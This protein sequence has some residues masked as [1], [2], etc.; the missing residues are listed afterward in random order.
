MCNKVTKR[1]LLV[2]SIWSEEE[3]DFLRDSASRMSSS[4]IAHALGRTVAAVRCKAKKLGVRFMI[5]HMKDGTIRRGWTSDEVMTLYSLSE[6]TTLDHAAERLKRSPHAVKKKASKLGISFRQGRMTLEDVSRILGISKNT[7]RRKRDRL[8]LSFRK[9]SKVS[10]RGVKK[11]GH[12]RGPTGKDIVV[13]AKDM[14]DNPP[15]GR[16]WKEYRSV[17][18]LR[19]I[20]ETYEGWE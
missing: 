10:R 16:E 5:E 13:I 14:L 19:E 6:W 7:V 4:E 3:M 18:D 11:E 8:G 12:M 2:A 17:K 15:K 20:I 1:R 9:V